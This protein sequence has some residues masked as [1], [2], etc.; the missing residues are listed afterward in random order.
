MNKFVFRPVG[1]GLFYTGSLNCG[2]FNF[3]YDCGTENRQK[4]IKKEIENYIGEFNENR[5]QNNRPI[6]DFVVISHLHQDHFSGLYEL[7]KKAY[8]KKIYLPFLNYNLD[9]I[10][11]YLF[12]DIYSNN[13]D[14]ENRNE[15]NWEEK[16]GLYNLMISLYNNDRGNNKENIGGVHFIKNTESVKNS[17]LLWEF[18]FFNKEPQSEKVKSINEKCE[19]FIQN[20]GCKDMEEFISKNKK[21]NK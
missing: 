13:N 20:S 11:L 10:R 2:R 9:V 18:K 8:I 12:Y 14:E 19:K 16:D 7:T 1:Q 3:V 21:N 17:H 4:L 5:N 15:N 6:I